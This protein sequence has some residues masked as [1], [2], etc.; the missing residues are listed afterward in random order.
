FVT[1]YFFLE[2]LAGFTDDLGG[3]EATRGLVRWLGERH[4]EPFFAFVNYL[5]AHAPYG[6]VPEPYFSAFSTRP[7]PRRIGGRWD[8]Q[9]QYFACRACAEPGTNPLT[10]G[11]AGPADDLQ[12]RQGRWRAGAEWLRD[13]RDLYDAGVLYADHQVGSLLDAL[14]AAGVL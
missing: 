11:P 12:C 8:R 2:R 9:A 13:A 4:G 1:S 6:S 3:A 14:A 10:G 5:E 7:L